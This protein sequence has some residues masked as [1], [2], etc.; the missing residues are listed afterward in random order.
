MYQ[1]AFDGF[2]NPYNTWHIAKDKKESY[3]RSIGY[4]IV[5]YANRYDQLGSE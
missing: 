1:D 2:G 4:Y 3:G 5:S